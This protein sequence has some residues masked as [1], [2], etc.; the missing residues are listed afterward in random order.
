[1]SKQLPGAIQAVLLR[2]HG[3][4]DC[5]CQSTAIPKTEGYSALRHPDLHSRT[6][7]GGC[8]GKHWFLV[9]WRQQG[10]SDLENTSK[11]RYHRTCSRAKSLQ[12]QTE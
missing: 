8:L 2:S 9:V 12:L 4:L 6:G 5:C 11:N 10:D 7:L 3:E 1:M